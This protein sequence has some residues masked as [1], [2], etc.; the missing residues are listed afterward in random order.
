[1]KIKS[2]DHIVLT[3]KDIEKTID[4]YVKI[5]NM[6]LETDRT[7]YSLRYGQQK[8]NLHSFPGEFQPAAANPVHGSADLCFEVEG[9]IKEIEEE[10][11]QK[12]TK[13]EFGPIKR[14]GSRGATNSI[15][16]RDPD[17]NLIELISYL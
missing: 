5:L 6:R 3:V 10:L 1:M 8:I 16:L 12:K 7:R 9:N 14:T 17:N 15:Y 13:I 4:F 11:K 2:I